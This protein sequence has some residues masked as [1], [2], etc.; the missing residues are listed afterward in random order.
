MVPLLKFYFH[1]DCRIAAA[2]C[3]PYLI[4]CAR[5][6]GEGMYALIRSGLFG[7][8]ARKTLLEIST[9]RYTTKFILYL[10]HHHE[11]IMGSTLGLSSNLSRFRFQVKTLKRLKRTLPLYVI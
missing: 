8:A 6:Q 11:K 4:D 9:N 7:I 3:L 2:E 1:D 5:I 10:L